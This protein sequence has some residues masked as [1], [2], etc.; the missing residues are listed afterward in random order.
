MGSS[1]LRRLHRGDGH[2]WWIQ[3]FNACQSAF[4]A[5]VSL[6]GLFGRDK[7]VRVISHSSWPTRVYCNRRTSALERKKTVECKETVSALGPFISN[8]TSFS[9]SEPTGTVAISHKKLIRIFFKDWKLSYESP[10]FFL[11]SIRDR[12]RQFLFAHPLATA[13][14]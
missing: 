1:H 12:D 6:C 11:K 9:N 8:A 5:S 3:T 7:Q 13:E 4:F 2:K 10:P 14:V